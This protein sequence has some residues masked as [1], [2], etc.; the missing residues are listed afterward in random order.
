[1]TAHGMD[2]GHGRVWG[3]SVR[4]RLLAALGR[5][6]D[7]RT[8]LDAVQAMFPEG[9]PEAARLVCGLPAAEVRLI[10]GDAVGALDVALEALDVEWPHVGL[11]LALAATGLRAAA[12]IAQ[13]RRAHR[14]ND[15]L[16][17]AKAFGGRCLGEVDAQRAILAGWDSPTPSKLATADLAEAELARLNGEAD[18]ERWAAIADAFDAAPMP[19]PAAYARYRQAEATLVRGGV[20]AAAGELLRAADGSARAL[21]AAPLAAAIARLA[22]QARIDLA[23][24]MGAAGPALDTEAGAPAGAARGA[25]TARGV[26][27]AG[28]SGSPGGGGSAEP[29]A[30]PP[31][32]RESRPT[33]S[34]RELQVLSLVAAGRTNGQIASELYISPKTASVHVTHILDKLG[35]SNRVEAAM[36]A[37]RAGL[38][39]GESG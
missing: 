22:R 6:A 26:G 14:D 28:G 38:L 5:T 32:R 33:L 17:R 29:P 35:A 37:A 1:M 31:T 18:P 11:R 21:G 16:S 15:G 23:S 27:A 36:I 4:A 10:E 9:L 12:D 19:Y 34:A 7:A 25:G 3:L 20:K 30:A 39:E 8:V 24:P 2:V 13:D